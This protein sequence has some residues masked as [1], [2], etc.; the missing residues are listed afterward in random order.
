[1][2]A[3]NNHLEKVMAD[4]EKKEIKKLLIKNGLV[5]WYII[6]RHTAVEIMK[7]VKGK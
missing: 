1:M 3:S 5:N 7:R 2:L 4:K 6:K